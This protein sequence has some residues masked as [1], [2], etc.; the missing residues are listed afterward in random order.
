MPPWPIIRSR[1]KPDDLPTRLKIV[2]EGSGQEF[3]LPL[4]QIPPITVVLGA[5]ALLAVVLALA[6][7]FVPQLRSGVPSQGIAQD[8][9]M[10]LLLAVLVV[11]SWALRPDGRK[12]KR[13]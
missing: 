6:L 10:S 7:T 2:H 9:G 1:G 3:V 11:G 13:A 12:L 4:R 8:L 5:A